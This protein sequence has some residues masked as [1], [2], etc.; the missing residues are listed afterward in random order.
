MTGL[1]LAFLLY[2][3]WVGFTI[4]LMIV[5]TDY[6]GLVYWGISVI[7]LMSLHVLL[8]QNGNSPFC[9]KQLEVTTLEVNGKLIKRTNT[10]YKVK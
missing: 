8:F 10:Y 9:K 7:V 4:Y 3:S 2:T 1:I 6:K 5:T